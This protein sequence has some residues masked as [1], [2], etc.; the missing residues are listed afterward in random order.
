MFVA[1]LETTVEESDCRVW[2]WAVCPAVKSPEDSDVIMGTDFVEFMRFCSEMDSTIY[3]HNLKFD[4]S[5]IIDWLLKNHYTHTLESPKPGQFSTLVSKDTKW[6]S[7]TVSWMSGYRTEFRDS[8]KKLPMSVDRIAKS[9]KL[10]FSKLVIDYDADRPVGYEPTDQEWE[11]LRHDVKI[12]AAAIA[13]TLDAGMTKLTVGADSLAEY[14]RN[15]GKRFSHLFPILD[16]VMDASVRMAYRGGWTF[17]DPRFAKRVVGPVWVFD[18]NSLYPSVMYDRPLP[19][20]APRYFEGP[21]D[22]SQ[23]LFIVAMTFTAKLREGRLPCIQ[24]KNSVFAQSEYLSEVSE[25]TTVALTHVDLRLWQEQY[26]LRVHSWNGGFYFDSATGLFKDYIDKWS[27]IKAESEGGLREIAKLH[28]NSLYGKFATNPEVTGKVPVLED[29][30]VKWVRGVD[31]TRDP[32]YTAMGVFITSYAR[33]VTIRAAQLN[34]EHFCYADTDSL[35]LLTPNPKGIEVDPKKLG[36]WKYEYSSDYALFWR[37]KTYI[38]RRPDLV[39]DMGNTVYETHV[40]GLPKRGASKLRLCDFRP[41]AEFDG[42]LLPKVVDG[43]TVL[44]E[45]TFK[46]KT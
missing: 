2:S 4:G 12:V 18:V 5:F 44:V 10:P 6:Y 43:G 40:A 9:F 31:E 33:D 42:K 23:G 20:G 1:D 11:Y 37:P 22:D 32:V 3:F 30:V 25:P 27:K 46:L 7:F 35:H 45:T 28:L 14:K 38:E 39:D 21:P 41:D 24:L 17:V 29:G 34:Y 26:D 36:A 8:L 19:V 13:M 16:P 15:M